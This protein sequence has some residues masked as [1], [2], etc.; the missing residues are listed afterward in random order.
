MDS[1]ANMEEMDVKLTLPV[2]FICY[3]KQVLLY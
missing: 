2:S 3:I 1:Q